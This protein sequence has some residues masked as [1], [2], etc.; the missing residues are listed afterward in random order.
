MKVLK[1]AELRKRKQVEHIKSERRILE[2]VNDPFVVGLHCAFQ[3][4]DKLCFVLDY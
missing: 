1:K 4:E 2:K 3:T